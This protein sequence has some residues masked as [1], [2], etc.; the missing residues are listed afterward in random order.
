MF[1]R[2]NT[3]YYRANVP[4]D[5][6][7]Y[8]PTTEIKKSLK[9]KES[10]TA[11]LMASSYEYKVQQAFA[12][13]RTGALPDDTIK[14][15]VESIVPTKRKA[16]VSKGKVLAD[17]LPGYKESKKAEWTAKTKMEA[18]GVIRLLLDLIGYAEISAITRP[19]VLELRSTL[20]KLPPNLYKKYPGKTIKQILAIKDIEPMSNKSVNKHVS[21]LGSMLKYCLEE[22]IITSNPATGLKISE[23]KRPDEERSAY[24]KAD[25]KKIISHLPVDPTKPERYWIP[26]IGLYSGMR[27]NEI[28]QLYASDII[29]FDGLWCFSINGEKDKHIKNEASDRVIPIHPTLIDLGFLE[30]VEQQKINNIPRLWMNLTYCKINGYCNIFSKWYSRFN[31]SNVTENPLK[32]FHSMR[33]TVTDKL[34]Q[35]GIIDTI[36]AELV[37]HSNSGSMTMGRYGKRYQPKVLLEALLKL[38]YGDSIPERLW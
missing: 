19:M 26:M 15:V 33:H 20:Q 8:F 3:Y 14:L 32:V 31:R 10:K 21:R 22:G 29:K 5:L 27:L 38:D 36:I 23:K 16:A 24:D 28:C 1:V 11:K 6:L 35:A 17:I 2:N 13:I 7:K 12:V 18:G 9:T 34:K 4:V 37:G 30:Y 25:V